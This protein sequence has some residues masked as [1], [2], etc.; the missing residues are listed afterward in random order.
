MHGRADVARDLVRI[1][2]AV[3]DARARERRDTAPIEHAIRTRSGSGI[4]GLAR[5]R[6]KRRERSSMSSFSAWWRSFATTLYR[7]ARPR[8]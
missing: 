7:A 3:H 8:S 2:V 5:K 4:A 1:G 6:R